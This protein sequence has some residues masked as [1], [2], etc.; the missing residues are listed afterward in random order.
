MRAVLRDAAHEQAEP[1]ARDQQ[2]H[3]D[4]HQRGEGEDRDAVVRQRQVGQHL[5]AARQPGRVLDADVLRAEQRA[6]RLHQDQADAP[7]R[8]QRLERPAVEPADHG[9]FSSTAPTS[10]GSEEADR[11]RGQ[12][13]AVEGAGRSGRGTGSARTRWRRRRSSSARRAPC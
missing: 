6:H 5:H 2:R 7:G 9:A 13:V 1:R 10:G 8:Q 4:Q 12:D 3:A 11:D